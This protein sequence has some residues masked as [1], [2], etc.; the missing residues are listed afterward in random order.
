MRRARCLSRRRVLEALPQWCCSAAER[1]IP[2]DYGP[3][4]VPMPNILFQK[5]IYIPLNGGHPHIILKLTGTVPHQK[6][7]PS[8]HDTLSV[9]IF[10]SSFS[11]KPL[12]LQHLQ[13]RDQIPVAGF[14]FFYGIASSTTFLDTGI[15]PGHS[16]NL[17]SALEISERPRQDH[18]SSA[19]H[20]LLYLVTFIF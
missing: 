19:S 7:L 11:K 13:C 8:Y 9:Q 10:S 2:D 16:R 15:L 14:H 17:T 3:E 6:A 5:L 4:T 12:F 20:I 1:F 18:L